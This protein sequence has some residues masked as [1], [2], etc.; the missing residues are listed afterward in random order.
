MSRVTSVSPR[1][2]IHL[3]SSSKSFPTMWTLKLLETIV[4]VHMVCKL[5]SNLIFFSLQYSLI[6]SPLIWPVMCFYMLSFLGKLFPQKLLNWGESVTSVCLNSVWFLI[7][8]DLTYLASHWL[9]WYLISPVW[10]LMCGRRVSLLSAFPHI[11]CKPNFS[12][13]SDKEYDH[14][15]QLW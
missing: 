2:N 8:G 11:S 15:V 4:H 10:I 9:R 5:I 12:P 14:E 7:S 13:R 1:M 6:S 3:L